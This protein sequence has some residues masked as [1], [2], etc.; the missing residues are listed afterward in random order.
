MPVDEALAIARQIAEALEEAHEKGIVHR[1]LKPANVKLTP[2]GKVKVL[3]FGLAKA[4]TGDGASGVL[5]RTL[6]QSPTLAHDGHRG[7]RD[8]RHRRLHVARAGARQAGRQ[9][10]RHLGLRRRALRDADGP[11]A[12]R[13]RD[14]HRRARGGADGDPDWTRSRRTPPARPPTARAL[15][16]QGP[17]GA[18][19][20]HRRRAARAPGRTSTDRSSVQLRLGDAAVEPAPVAA[21][22]GALLVA[23]GL[24][25]APCRQRTAAR[26]RR[27]ST[28]SRSRRSSSR[29]RASLRTAARWSSARHARG[30][31]PSFSCGTRGPATPLPGRRNVQLLSV[32]SKASSRS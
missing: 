22:G 19:A 32:S 31:R 20:R 23:V 17:E 9:A 28:S 18:A 8:P 27:A 25:A 14:R 21:G 16:A 13:G 3:D 12:L 30:T 2:D 4:W 7:R 10:R 15:P 5:R 26:S 29:T 6:S 1:D 11:P 24:A